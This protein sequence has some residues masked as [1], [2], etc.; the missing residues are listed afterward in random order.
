MADQMDKFY[1]ELQTVP[2]LIRDLALGVA[3]AQRAMDHDY[4]LNLTEFAKVVRS[5]AGQSPNDKLS[6]EEFISLFRAMGPSRHQITETTAEVHADLQMAS[7]SELK[8]GGELSIKA[9]LFAVAINASYSRRNAYNAEASATIKTVIHSVSADPGVME[10]LLARAAATPSTEKPKEGRW[11]DISDAF[12]EL[13]KQ[14]PGSGITLESLDPSSAAKGSEDLT[15]TLKGSGFAAGLKAQ[16]VK[17]SKTETIEATDIEATSAKI[18]VPKSLLA[19]ATTLKISLSQG[20]KTS[21][22]QDFEVKA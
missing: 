2:K 9:A 12:T 10:K 19:T 13:F 5:V 11:Q 16:V 1:N 21:F 14:L 18:K 22:P 8:V 4:L 17:A 6:V 3:E 15:V 20:D 7:A